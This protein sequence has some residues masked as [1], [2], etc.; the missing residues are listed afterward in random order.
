MTSTKKNGIGQK[1]EKTLEIIA[2][3]NVQREGLSLGEGPDKLTIILQSGAKHTICGLRKYVHKPSDNLYFKCFKKKNGVAQL[4]ITLPPGVPKSYKILHALIWLIIE[5][6]KCGHNRQLINKEL[7]KLVDCNVSKMTRNINIRQECLDPDA[8]E[9]IASLDRP[10]DDSAS[11]L[12]RNVDGR[13]YD[14]FDQLKES[15]KS[16]LG[17]QTQSM[18]ELEDEISG[19]KEHFRSKVDKLFE[20]MEELRQ[21][22]AATQDQ[23]DGLQGQVDGLQ[24]QVN[25]NCEQ[26]AATQDQL[27][28]LQDQVNEDR[29]RQSE[30]N[31][32]QSEISAQ[33]NSKLEELEQQIAELKLTNSKHDEISLYADDD[34]Q[35]WSDE[36][37]TTVPE[38]PAVEFVTD[39][40]V[41]GKPTDEGNKD[42]TKAQDSRRILEADLEERKLG[43]SPKSFKKLAD[44]DN[45]GTT[46]APDKPNDKV[47]TE[48][49][50]AQ[51]KPTDK[52]NTES[53]K[54]QD[55]PTNIVNTDMTTT[56]L[57]KPTIN[58]NT[59]STTVQGKLADIVSTGIVT[60][61]PEKPTDI[62]N[63]ESTKA[64]EKP[65]DTV[66]T[67]ISTM[68]PDK[69]TGEN[70]VEPITSK[71]DFDYLNDELI[72]S[73]MEGDD[74][75]D[76]EL[77][78]DLD[79]NDFPWSDGVAS[80]ED[81]IGDKMGSN[82]ASS[83]KQHAIDTA[84]SDLTLPGY[85]FGD[86]PLPID[87]EINID[88]LHFFLDEIGSFDHDSDASTNGAMTTEK[89]HA[90]DIDTPLK[91]KQNDME[92]PD[93]KKPGAMT[94]EKP[95]DLENTPP[96]EDKTMARRNKRG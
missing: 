53:T 2:W 40:M 60:T 49:T 16:Q 88:E 74:G 93:K 41:P 86:D 82:V 48:S 85:Y 80:V 91:D 66:N 72:S 36:E 89:P 54:A 50:N 87:Q 13:L 84:M 17:A 38:K 1:V 46:T 30:I 43:Q 52:V 19:L 33:V 56:G 57:D 4:L 70:K 3:I 64:P 15:V 67:G 62:V 77:A 45:T 14:V 24:D 61:V 26:Q 73:F 22:Q 5:T 44:E 21:R 47:N 20:D 51:D 59:E 63:Q 78:D 79:Y 8:F 11:G 32:Q 83:G 12:V 25:E 95:I 37:D 34:F 18:K 96:V 7:C 58:D 55:K 29:E 39:T 35:Q 90:T 76:Y 75:L 10:F 92:Q 65:T 9:I 71:L 69:P 94:V 23:V 27:D 42:T 68:V 28:G 31:K 6:G 81:T